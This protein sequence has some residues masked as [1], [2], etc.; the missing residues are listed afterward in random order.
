M[1]TTPRPYNSPV[2]QAQVAQTRDRI[3]AAGA[4]AAHS[5]QSWDWR[6]L[7]VRSVAERAGVNE[8]TVYRHFA[9]E[10]D[11]R[12]AILGRLLEEAGVAVDDLALDDFAQTTSRVVAYLSTFATKPRI[13]SDPTFA[14]VDDQR[15]AALVS[16]LEPRTSSWSAT[17]RRQAAALLDVFWSL[18]PLVRLGTAWEL[19]EDEIAGAIGWVIGLIEAAI[20]QGSRPPTRG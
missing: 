19:P 18:P 20:A 4:E 7:T 15:R 11:L 10:K 14:A 6:D 13:V 17:Q 8:R 1:A 2:R 3:V 16:A 9:T 12:D 5:L